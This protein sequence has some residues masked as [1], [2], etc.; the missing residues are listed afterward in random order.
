MQFAQGRIFHNF[1]LSFST[2][3]LDHLV[4]LDPFLLATIMRHRDMCT[5]F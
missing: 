5:T 4:S 1:F 3:L 2:S